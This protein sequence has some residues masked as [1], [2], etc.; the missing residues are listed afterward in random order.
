MKAGDTI[1]FWL[2]L[3]GPG[4]VW[5]SHCFAAGTVAD[6]LENVNKTDLLGGTVKAIGQ[7]K[8]YETVFDMGDEERGVSY[9]AAWRV[10]D[11]AKA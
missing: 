7:M 9:P 5:T 1:K 10:T 2:D 6:F 3:E 4:S 8:V 11:V